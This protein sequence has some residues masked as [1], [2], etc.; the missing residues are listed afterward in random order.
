VLRGGEL[1]GNRENW[2]GM[3]SLVCTK[4]DVCF[5]AGISGTFCMHG[6]TL[7]LG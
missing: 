4:L 6:E 7:G 3:D 1:L 2:M 5:R